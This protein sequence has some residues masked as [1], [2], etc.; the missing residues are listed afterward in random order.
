MCM[1][2][3]I[4]V[5]NARTQRG[6]LGFILAITVASITM[7]NFSEGLLYFQI[8]L[9]VFILLSIFIQFEFKID[10]GYLTLQKRSE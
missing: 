4:L 6:V 8:L 5:Y 7:I 1:R 9:A 2:E 3:G 10:D